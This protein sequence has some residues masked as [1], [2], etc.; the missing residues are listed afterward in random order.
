[1]LCQYAANKEGHPFLAVV[2]VT[3]GSKL[4]DGKKPD[5]LMTR[6]KKGYGAYYHVEDSAG[7]VPIVNR[8]GRDVTIPNAWICP[9][10][11]LVLYRYPERI[12]IYLKSDE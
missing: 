8:N 4:I 11:L 12:N 10:T 3:T 6:Y 7:E 5:I 2:D 9:V 1:M